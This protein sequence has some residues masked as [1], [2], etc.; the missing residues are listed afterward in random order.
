MS[1]LPPSEE[2]GSNSSRIEAVSPSG[3]I[4]VDAA[5][6]PAVLAD[7]WVLFGGDTPE[8]QKYAIRIVSQCV[9]SSGCERNWS[10][11]AL[12]HT[13]VRNCLGYEKLRKLVYV[14]QI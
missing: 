6:T 8:L 11:F 10:T 2:G 14:R 13:K 5:P 4:D 9:S 12:V 1:S 7:W 3:P